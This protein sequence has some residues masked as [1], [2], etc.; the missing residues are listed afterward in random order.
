MVTFQDY[1]KYDD[2]DGFIPSVKEIRQLEHY[3][4]EAL[5]ADELAC[6]S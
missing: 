1:E 6:I 4:F 3:F 2:P 5:P